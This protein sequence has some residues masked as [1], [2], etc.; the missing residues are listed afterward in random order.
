MTRIAV[1]GGG[2][3]GR[4][5]ADVIRRS[6]ELALAAVV[7]PSDE[8]YAA[9]AALG[10]PVSDVTFEEVKAKFGKKKRQRRLSEKKAQ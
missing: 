6:P 7:D 9:A 10:V 5:H 2:L 1:M 3:I 4:R 8:G